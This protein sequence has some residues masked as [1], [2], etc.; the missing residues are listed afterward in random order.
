MKRTKAFLVAL[1]FIVSIF[2]TIQDAVLAYNVAYM[3]G[4]TETGRS[5]I[6]I[7]FLNGN[8][9]SVT[10]INGDAATLPTLSELLT[11]DAIMVSPNHEW[12][13]AGRSIELGNLL[14]DYVDAGGGLVMTTFSW[15]YP[16]INGLHGRLMDGGYSPF[17]GG[18][19]LYS[20]ASLESFTSHPIMEGV[21]E[22]SGFYRDA[23]VPSDDAQIIAAWSDGTPFVAIDAGSGVVGI[24]L[25][26]ESYPWEI[27]GDYAKL[28]VN[29]L[30]WTA[31]HKKQHANPRHGMGWVVTIDGM[32]IGASFFPGWPDMPSMYLYEAITPDWRN[33]IMVGL[34]PIYPFTW[35]RD[36][37]KTNDAVN[38]LY[39]KI[40]ELNKTN[41]PITILSHSWGTILS[42]IV[43]MKHEDIHV[44]KLITMG[45]P[46]N[47]A[48]A[49]IN[50]YTREW[51]EDFG[52][53]SISKPANLREW[54]NYF[55]ICDLIS[56]SMPAIGK[57]EDYVNKKIY[58]T[59][60]ACHSAYFKDSKK[61]NKILQDLVSK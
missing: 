40:K 31:S 9:D 34:G 38:Q 52:I 26:A 37:S 44:D 53:S 51:L 42:Y 17:T 54:H 6:A 58:L 4:N 30:N 43:I 16:D 20:T 18:Y 8:F 49:P 11:Y 12:H 15:Q 56:G 35:S 36:L 3:Y 45:S 27:N 24:N 28:F 2:F 46:L 60:S 13:Y 61:W 19:S 47:S 22:I 59:S 25:F 14:A 55:A 29:A 23:V 21:N 57:N 41:R 7:N 50:Y 10:P 39:E 33:K 48:F 1:V 5:E 32:D